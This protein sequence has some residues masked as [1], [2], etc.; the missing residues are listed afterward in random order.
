MWGTGLS[1]Q[2]LVDAGQGEADGASE[3]PTSTQP[4]EHGVGGEQGPSGAKDECGRAA[5]PGES[6]PA[7]QVPPEVASAS[8]LGTTPPPRPVPRSPP[9]TPPF[10]ASG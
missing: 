6:T 1:G 9:H 10:S 3:P 4:L 5:A 2:T 7:C 8:V